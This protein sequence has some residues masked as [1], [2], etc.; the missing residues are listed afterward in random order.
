M[1]GANIPYHLRTKKY[2]ERL[3]FCE[4][5]QAVSSEVDLSSHLY[6]SMGGP[7]LSDHK[8][9]ETSINIER[10]LSIEKERYV[11]PR[12]EFNKD[13]E[14]IT[15]K[16]MDTAELVMNFSSI[17]QDY[18]NA[19]NVIVW[20]DYAKAKERHAQITEFGNLLSQLKNRDIIKI[21]VNCSI[22][23][24]AGYAIPGLPGAAQQAS[25]DKKGNS[26][27]ASCMALF[28]ADH[29]FSSTSR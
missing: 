15:C 27:E 29:S 17:L 6:I 3:L 13:S 4:L 7:F 23:T 2:I 21:S 12:Q 20:L 5:L 10:L 24:L 28:E 14:K 8:V 25:M 26:E 19:E 11:V 9:M 18:D 16:Q 22:S 1:A